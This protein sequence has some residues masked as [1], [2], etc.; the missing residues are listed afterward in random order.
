MF[1]DPNLYRHIVD[2]LPSSS[3]NSLETQRFYNHTSTSAQPGEKTGRVDDKQAAAFV[4]GAIDKI[5]SPNGF[6]H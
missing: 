1:F 6:Y 3:N 5:L 2:L 4:L